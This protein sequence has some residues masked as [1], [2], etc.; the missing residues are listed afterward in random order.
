MAKKKIEENE[1]RMPDGK[2]AEGNKFSPGSQQLKEL[3]T[4]KNKPIHHFFHLIKYRKDTILKKQ[5]KAK[6][7]Q[8]LKM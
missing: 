8:H 2:F 6:L 3:S 5:K 7:M 4:Q 1:G